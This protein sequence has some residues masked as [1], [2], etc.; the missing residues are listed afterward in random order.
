MAESL[1][2]SIDPT[3]A[4]LAIER[5]SGARRPVIYRLD[6]LDAVK[7]TDIGFLIDISRGGMKIRCNAGVDVS[8]L[9]KLKLTLPRWLSLGEELTMLGRVAWCKPHREGMVECGF[10]FDETAQNA[11]LLEKLINR[12]AEAAIEDGQL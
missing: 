8:T 5:R 2:M 4:E 11:A 10:A 7:G 12:L 3:L 1:R 9:T 6:V